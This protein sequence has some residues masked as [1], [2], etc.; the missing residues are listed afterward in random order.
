MKLT[1]EQSAALRSILQ[2]IANVWDRANEAEALIPG[3]EI[4]TASEDV[5]ELAAF[6]EDATDDDLVRVFG[7]EK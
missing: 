7:L 1:G 3:S 5:Y 2:G 4:N 6:H